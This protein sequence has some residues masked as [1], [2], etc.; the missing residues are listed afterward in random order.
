MTEPVPSL[1]A[2]AF[3][4]FAIPPF[5]TALG[6]C[7]LTIAV[8]RRERAS[9]VSRLFAVMAAAI[10]VWLFAFTGMYS[11]ASDDAARWWAQAAYLG[12]PFIPSAVY[13][14]SLEVLGKAR[15]RRHMLIASWI[16][17]GVF[18]VIAIGTD[19]LIAGM[20]SY[21]WGAYPRYGAMSIPYLVFFFA[22]MLLT[23][24]HYR[25]A[26]RLAEPG[27][28][29]ARRTQ[30]LLTAF[31]IVYLGS[32]DYLA[33]FGLP[34]YPC[35]FVPVMIFLI[36]TARA[37]KRYRLIDIT[38]AFTAEPILES[39]RE[40][41]IVIDL[42][43]VIRLVNRAA[44]ELLGVPSEWVRGRTL[45]GLAGHAPFH[46]DLGALVQSDTLPQYTE[47]LYQHPSGAARTLA[48]STSVIRDSD[49]QPAAVACFLR[50]V[51]P[52]QHDAAL[53]ARVGEM[54]R[55]WRRASTNGGGTS[56]AAS[57][58]P[59]RRRGRRE[60]IRVSAAETG[61]GFPL[62]VP[63]FLSSHWKLLVTLGMLLGVPLLVMMW[64]EVHHAER[65][66]YS[67]AQ[68]QHIVSAKLAA[69]AVEEH[70][71]GLRH[72]V[73]SFASRSLLAHAVETARSGT[74]EDNLKE[75]VERNPLLDRA[76]VVDASGTLW[77]DYPVVQSVRGENFAHRRW[78]QEVAAAKAPHISAVYERSADPQVPLVAIAVPIR[79]SRQVL[80]GY[81]VAQHPLSALNE[82]F[83]G[84]QP[85]SLGLVELL[86]GEHRL[87]A[88]N[89]PFSDRTWPVLSR[90]PAIRD[91]GREGAGALEVRS[92]GFS[93]AFM[94]SYAPIASM[95]WI[96]LIA[97]PLSRVLAPARALQSS[98]L[99]IALLGFLTAIAIGY[100]ALVSLR[101]SHEMLATS[102]AAKARHVA[103]LRRALAE[104]AKAEEALKQ[105]AF[106]VESSRDAIIG[107]RLDR[108]IVTW[109]AAAERLFGYAE[110]EVVG[111][112][113]TM[114]I[115]P[116][117]P[118]EIPQMLAELSSG[119]PVEPLETV[120]IRR[121]GTPIALLMTLSP[122]KNPAGDI[123][124]ASVIAHDI[125]ER[126]HQEDALRQM[127][128]QLAERQRA[129]M[130]TLGKLHTAHRELKS[131]QLQLIQAAKMESVGR[132]A[133]G[134]AHEVKNPLATLLMGLDVLTDHYPSRKHDV[135]SLLTD[136][137]HAVRRADTVIRGLVD[138]SAP[139]ELARSREDLNALIRQALVLT[140]HQQ[141]R[142]HVT[143][144]ARF[145]PL[146]ALS[147]DR[148]KIEQVFLNLILNAVQAMP[149]GGVLSLTT[150]VVPA[151]RVRP[152]NG[153][154]R[155][156]WT[157][158]GPLVVEATV[159][160]TG[161]GIPREKLHKVFDP[162]FT[163]KATGQGT[164]LGLAVSRKIVELHGGTMLLSNRAEGGVEVS[165]F[166]NAERGN[167]HGTAS[168]SARG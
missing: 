132:L 138:F 156:G 80:L 55:A 83:T 84:N 14:F 97:Q 99:V 68:A 52:E 24:H 1:S 142:H 123:I 95:R 15:E 42:E 47:I 30:A 57:G 19:W 106:I 21:W 26:A 130:A 17:S 41:L 36:L 168:H 131:T 127:N 38:P 122:V 50:N 128:F 116:G 148:T 67:Q 20:T 137:Q 109:N 44:C 135:I 79:N 119:Q 115:P 27:S 74:V 48:L 153:Q 158:A 23:L 76:F 40:A 86:D 107:E 160:D 114:L 136:M 121:D 78:F 81:L 141:N 90:L 143:V 11:A 165:V 108:T 87:A 10:S 70:L 101:H 65:W 144:Q 113:M 152:S 73:E 149:E 75:L 117:S 61:V 98:G 91:L 63:W 155:H 154:G 77:A 51:T 33:K 37:V 120:R 49:G 31:I 103:S 111:R 22:M 167:E 105:L 72:Y 29:Q 25:S 3:N 146:P 66:L 129:L 100:L 140:K 64:L 58:D 45:T 6:L 9:Y 39:M 85:A 125:T 56:G 104:R 164:G 126:K 139:H 34:V 82:W 43:G 4:P 53:L 16:L 94:T 7:A 54:S 32:V 162:F 89:V 46:G 161:P 28:L 102:D 93:E 96:V 2:Y 92:D 145:A 166:F 5:L 69:K 124:G 133:A 12:V 147:L 118:D 71:Q 13:H 18:A 112:S 150:A 88:R 163:T 62:P 8:V 157:P 60:G 110:Q 134:V 59:S 35:G 159:S 151:E